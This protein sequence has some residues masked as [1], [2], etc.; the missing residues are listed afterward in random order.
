MNWARVLSLLILLLNIMS[1]F[2]ARKGE[3]DIAGMINTALSFHRNGEAEQA[4]A[5]YDELVPVMVDKVDANF[6]ATVHSNRGALLMQAGSYESAKG[7][8]EAAVAA[9]PENINA[10]FNLAVT[11]TSKLGEHLKAI[12]HCAAVLKQDGGHVKALHLMGNIMQSLDRPADAEKYFSKAA[13]AQR[14]G[15]EEIVGAAAGA[16]VSVSARGKAL[17]WGRWGGGA[18]RLATAAVGSSFTHTHNEQ[19]FTMTC[20]SES[21]R[22]F[23]IESLLSEVECAAIKSR[24]E[25]QLEYSYVTG[26][27]AVD[28][29]DADGYRTSINAWL[30]PDELLLDVQKRLTG[31]LRFYVVL[32]LLRR[33]HA[34]LCVQLR[35]SCGDMY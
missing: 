34:S 27:T 14:Q 29:D 28:R 17:E 5:A 7:A 10:R 23:R 26:G 1:T 25:P 32:L 35:C 16:K 9:Q 4:L 19:T 13:Q 30:S 18:G 21:P 12:R 22:V 33:C 24:A 2:A 31:M 20:L 6:A 8:F 15:Q 11:L 3:P